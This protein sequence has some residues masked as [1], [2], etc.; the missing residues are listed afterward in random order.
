MTYLKK[1][2]VLLI[3]VAV[4]VPPLKADEIHK[5]VIKGDLEAVKALLAKE[6]G[7]IDT[8]D[9]RGRTALLEAVVSG[10][11]E[12][13][14]FL[15]SRGA[16]VNPGDEHGVNPILMAAYQGKEELVKLLI[17]EGAAVN[18]ATRSGFNSLHGAAMQGHAAVVRMLIVFGGKVNALTEDGRTPLAI[19]AE[20]GYAEAVTAL[21]EKMTTVDVKDKNGATPLMIAV[22]GGHAGAVNALLM[23]G[24]D[25]NLKNKLGATAVTLAAREGHKEIMDLLV[26]RGAKKTVY[27]FPRLTGDYL[28]QKAPGADPVVF[29]P[30]I[31]S[32][33]KDEL[34]SIFMPDG[35]EFYFTVRQ[36]RKWVIMKMKRENNRWSA[37]APASFS[38]EYSDVDHM[39]SPD[40]R[41]M[42]YCSNRPLEPKGKKKR[43]FDIWV[44]DRVKDGWSDPRNLGAPVNSD[45]SEFYPSLTRDGVLYFQATR[46]DTRGGRDL[47]R[48]R[49]VNGKYGPLEN[50]GDVVNG[51]NSE[52]DVFVHPDGKYIV[53]SAHRD[54]GR[55]R[56]DLYISFSKGETWTRPA[57]LGDAVNT[58]AHEN[59][60][61]LSP[62]GEY[63]FFTRAGDIYWMDATV[64]DASRVME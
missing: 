44:V 11:D 12:I 41:Q 58:E 8:Q 46:P 59:C 25:Y 15:I 20:G 2:L 40:G 19:A 64:L 48:S 35:A 54:G 52:G 22:L 34:N 9:G 47:Y 3:V 38:G 61:V 7:V 13:A 14:M 42:F 43:D 21:A 57:G 53:F 5:A 16:D 10:K 29:A 49:N 1:C 6:P 37:P 62:D 24:A 60:P 23:Q 31:V 39:L 28:G 45:K 51:K 50:L 55:G 36:K 18:A 63:F 27:T 17:K 4:F 26:K 30:G 32:T 56:G 33:E